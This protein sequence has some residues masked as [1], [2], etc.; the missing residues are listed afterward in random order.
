MLLRLLRCRALPDAQHARRLAAYRGRQRHGRV[1]DELTFVQRFLQARQRLRL[2][3]KRH[4]EHDDLRFE[5][6]L[7]VLESR[8]GPLRDQL[9]GP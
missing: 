3:A 1:D 6:R 9:R 7:G 4:A 2:A 5:D 8:E